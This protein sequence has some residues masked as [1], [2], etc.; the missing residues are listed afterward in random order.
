MLNYISEAFC[1]ELVSCWCRVSQEQDMNSSF[2]SKQDQ[3]D[4]KF[5]KLGNHL[6]FAQ[7]KL[8]FWFFLFQLIFVVLVP[9]LSYQ[10]SKH[11]KLDESIVDMSQLS[12][13]QWCA[14]CLCVDTRHVLNYKI[15]KDKTSRESKRRQQACFLSW[16]AGFF[17]PCH[18]ASGH[19]IGE[20]HT[21]TVPG[22]CPKPTR[23]AGDHGR[24]LAEVK[25]L[26]C[27]EL[28]I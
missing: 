11:P 4:N 6:R 1:R 20:V 2:S 10:N 17:L 8:Q 15:R 22:N 16:V 13:V 26:K 5:N 9:E 23:Y 18:C 3:K 21:H 7:H 25:V 27:F 12:D 28:W 19:N 14:V 24:C